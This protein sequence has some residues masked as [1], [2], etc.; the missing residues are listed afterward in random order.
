M[1]AKTKRDQINH[2][3]A[4]PHV[5]GQL[6][7]AATFETRDGMITTHLFGAGVPIY[8][9]LTNDHVRDLAHYGLEAAELFNKE[10]E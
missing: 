1:S 10:S 9:K 8:G 3:L 4:D 7:L 2:I 5:S 6:R